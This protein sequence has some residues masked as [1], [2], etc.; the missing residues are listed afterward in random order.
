MNFF[1]SCLNFLQGEMT[2]PTSYGW[3]HLLALLLV[4]L[5]TVF[6]LKKW[7]NCDEKTFRRIMLFWWITVVL[8][9]VYK[10]FVFSF[11]YADGVLTYDY[12]WYA[13]PY[14]FCST[15]LYVV[16]FV[17]FLPEGKVRDACTFFLGLFSLFAGVAVMLYPGDVFIEMIGINIQTMVHHGSQV[18]FGIFSA[19]RILTQ[20]KYDWKHY[21]GAVAVFSVMVGIAL[22]LNIVMHHALLRWGID[23]TFNMFYISPYHDCTLPLLSLIYPHVHPVVFIILYI[24]GFAIVAGIIYWAVYGVEKLVAYIHTKLEKPTS[25]T[26]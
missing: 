8:F 12:Q 6:F 5:A 13:F 19:H 4:V 20:K 3:F 24:I 16:P 7:G 11:T 10:Q 26:L 18:V 14:Q 23:E 15:P 2:T 17:A 21:L 25:D 22:L 1:G 9:E